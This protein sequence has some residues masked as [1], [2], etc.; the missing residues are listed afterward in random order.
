MHGETGLRPLAVQPV[1]D[2]PGAQ[3]LMAALA[4]ERMG[5]VA[6]AA[7]VVETARAALRGGRL[8]EQDTGLFWVV[9]IMLL[10]LADEPDAMPAW[11]AAMAAM[12]RNGWLFASLGIN[13]WRGFTLLR[14]GQVEEAE[15]LLRAAQDQAVQWGS[16][17]VGFPYVL[18]TLSACLLERDDPDGA[19]RVLTSSPVRVP[20]GDGERLCL[21]ALAEVLLAEGRYAEALRTAEEADTRLVH[22]RNPTYRRAPAQRARAL[23][24]LGRLPEAL[25]LLQAQLELARAWGR[26]WA[27]GTALREL[28]EALGADGGAHLAEAVGVL[29]GSPA[30]LELA[31]SLLA[32]GR[33]T[34]E[35]APAEALLR[36]ALE[37]A[38]A[39]G[40]LRTARLAAAELTA[41][42][43]QVP[44]ARTTGADLLTST[45]RRICHLLGA[46]RSEREVAEELFL[47][48][49]SVHRHVESA[50]RK[51]ALASPRDLAVAPV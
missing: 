21:E 22:L 8:Y 39:G 9:A 46:G 43:A 41:R 42:G 36:R 23:A 35:R 4:Y 29:D 1:G 48:P 17:T 51:L 14:L 31:R 32:L 15:D 6:P 7:E 20:R 28:G 2:G 44:P 3:M 49:P 27:L 34:P 11:E 37:T 5:A 18:A 30:R 10:A 13:L 16:V 26:P 12:Y 33:A 19:R 50:A 40:T 25:P 47:T 24:G 38:R 45:E